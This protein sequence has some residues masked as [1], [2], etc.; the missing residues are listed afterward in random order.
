M[1]KIVLII[2]LFVLTVTLISGC[3]IPSSG[4]GN[5]NGD[6]NIIF[7][8][9]HDGDRVVY[10]DFIVLNDEENEEI[11]IDVTLTSYVSNSTIPGRLLGKYGWYSSLNFYENNNG[12]NRDLK[13]EGTPQYI[14][15]DINEFCPVYSFSG[16]TFLDFDDVNYTDGEYV[17]KGTINLSYVDI[18]KIN[19]SGIKVCVYGAFWYLWTLE[20]Y[21]VAW[22]EANYFATNGDYVE[23]IIDKE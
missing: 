13:M 11:K 14:I 21:N 23:V 8:P 19:P 1:K 18:E 9:N 10:S 2:S 22:D 7:D 3:E 17:W 15:K 12:W 20:D 5:F 6:D 4:G 16:E